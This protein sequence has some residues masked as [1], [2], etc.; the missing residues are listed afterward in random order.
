MIWIFYWLALL[1]ASTVTIYLIVDCLSH[2]ELDDYN[3][4]LN[5]NINQAEL[6]YLR[7]KKTTSRIRSKPDL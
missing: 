1:S 6:A 3:R 5:D 7:T 2:D 4:T